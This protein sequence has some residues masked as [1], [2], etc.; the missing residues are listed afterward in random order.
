MPNRN[1]V[2]RSSRFARWR[3]E[4]YV[5]VGI[6]AFINDGFD[7]AHD[8]L[9]DP[10]LDRVQMIIFGKRVNVVHKARFSGCTRM[11]LWK[12]IGEGAI[13]GAYR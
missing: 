8:S 12:E 5:S 13:D 11:I 2:Y 10:E 9:Q 1:C 6:C 7:V 3:L 4:L